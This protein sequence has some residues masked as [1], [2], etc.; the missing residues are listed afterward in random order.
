MLGDLQKPNKRIVYMGMSSPKV[1]LT[2]RNRTEREYAEPAQ[3]S[4][5]NPD[6]NLKG[7]SKMRTVTERPSFQGDLCIRRITEIPKGLTPAKPER[8]TY[9]LA[10]SETGHHHV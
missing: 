5:K 4:D 1:T 2:I 3:R 7:E 10:H 8:G 6:D 9:I